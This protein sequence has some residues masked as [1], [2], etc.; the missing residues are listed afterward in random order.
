MRSFN[1][2][3]VLFLDGDTSS[4]ADALSAIQGEWESVYGS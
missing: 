1:E 3:L 4:S 2:Q